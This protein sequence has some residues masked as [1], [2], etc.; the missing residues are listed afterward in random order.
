MCYVDDPFAALRGTN[1]RKRLLAAVM[2][3][4]WE[5]MGCGLGYP[6]GQLNQT[7]HWIGGTITCSP[8]CVTA[9]VKESIIVDIISDLLRMQKL[10]VLT[11][12]ELHSLLGKFGHAAGLLIV[13]RP[14]LQP[15][16]AAL[17]CTKHTGAPPECVW[18]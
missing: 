3:L 4:V 16:W 14:F 10:N 8:G 7:V 12:K 11:K 2:I 18:R 5:S 15:L 6:K 1:A 17:A 9:S 13:T